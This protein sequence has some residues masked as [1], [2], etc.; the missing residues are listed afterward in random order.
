MGAGQG[1]AEVSAMWGPRGPGGTGGQLPCCQGVES[2]GRQPL[3][4]LS[5]MPPHTLAKW[6]PGWMGQPQSCREVAL[7]EATP[8][9]WDLSVWTRDSACRQPSQLCVCVSRLCILPIVGVYPWIDPA[10]CLLVLP[11]AQWWRMM[12]SLGTVF[13]QGG[14]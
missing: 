3:F 13:F 11:G 2:Q 7:A 5:Q 10:V 9:L 1:S 6:C 4:P 14:R 8:S 12:L